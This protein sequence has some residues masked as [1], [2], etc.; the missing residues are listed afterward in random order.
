MPNV[1]DDNVVILRFDNSDFEK[2]T[3]QSMDTLDK[4][5]GSL[6][7]KNGKTFDGIT[8]AANS[9]DLSGLGRS[10][11]T[12]NS[13]FSNMGIVGMSVI[14]RLT[15]SAITSA[16][17]LITAIPKQA[18]QG[19]WQR[20]LNIEQAQFLIEG[21]GFTWKNTAEQAE[22]GMK[23]VYT[24]VDNAV[25]GTRYALDEA[26]IVASQLL[27]S[28]VT[29]MDKLERG[30][31]S[32]SG[33]ASVVN[34]NYG[35][36]GRIFAQVAGQGRMMGDDLLQLQ[37]RGISAADM[38]ADYL[39]INKEAAKSALDSAIAQGRQVKKMEE[40]REHSKLTGADVREMV[41][42]GA[43]DFEI[44]SGSFE[45]LFDQAEKANDTYTGSLANLKSAINRIG[46]SFMTIKMQQLTKI[47]NAL[48]P[49]FKRIKEF[50]DPLAKSV[51]ALS[52]KFSNFLIKG[53][54]DPVGKAIGYE[55]FLKGV[56][57]AAKDTADAVVGSNN[58]NQKSSKKTRS[59]ILKLNKEYQAAR[60]IFYKGTYGTGSNRK[61]AL[62]KIGISYKKTQ[63]II[64]QFYRDGFKWDKIEKQLIK[65]YK[66]KN[67]A[68]DDSTDLS[69]KATDAAE[70]QSKKYPAIIAL[71][72][73]FV[74]VLSSV[75]LLFSG[76]KNVLITIGGAF[77][78][79]ITPGIKSAAN[80]FSSFTEKILN[81][82]KK[83][84]TFSSNF[85]KE[86]PTGEWFSKQSP[87]VQK[88]ITALESGFELIKNVVGSAKDKIVDFFN[89][90]SESELLT[91]I[92]DWI[93]DFADS[94]LDSFINKVDEL[95]SAMSSGT[96][97]GIV[98]VLSKWTSGIS[99][100]NVALEKGENP[101]KRYSKVYDAFRNTISFK[102][103]SSSIGNAELQS[104]SATS[105]TVA[106]LIDVSRSIK[107]A[108]IPETFGGVTE[109]MVNFFSGIGNAAKKIDA[110]EKFNKIFEVFSEVDWESASKTALNIGL[111]AGTLK[112]V[113]DMGNVANAAVG[114]L[115][116][117][118]GF[119]ASLSGLAN[120]YKSQIYV[121]TFSI[122]ALSVAVLV[123]SIVSLA[124]VPKDRLIPAMVG[125]VTIVGMLVGVMALINSSKFDPKKMMEAGAAF[126]LLGA[127]IL[128]ISTSCKILSKIN[129]QDLFKAVTAITIFM[130]MFIMAAKMKG[131]IAKAG[132]TFW[133]MAA[134]VNM[135]AFAVMTFAVMPWGVIL[136][137]ATVI[138]ML[139][140]ELTLASRLARGAD[141]KG[142]AAMALALNL[143]IPPIIIFSIM[144]IDKALRGA[145]VVTSIIAMIGLASRTA[146]ASAGNMMTLF[147][148][149]TMVTSLT[150]ALVVL[151]FIDTEKLLAATL[152]LTATMAALAA[153]A[154]IANTAKAGM[155]VMMATI[156]LM[157]AAII[158]LVKIDAKKAIEVANSL[159]I[160]AASLGVATALFA[161]V[162]PGLALE[163]LAAMAIAVGG[164][165]AIVMALGAIRQIPGANWLMNEGKKFAQL[166]GEAIGSFVGGIVAGAGVA[167]SSGL[168][169][170]GE[171]LSLFMEKIDPF[172]SKASKID[173]KSTEGIKNLSNAIV[174]LTKAEFLDQLS[175]LGG[176][177]SITNFAN[178][179]VTFAS[180]F[181]DFSNKVKEIP[182]GSV[183]KIST[184]TDSIS[185]LATAF[186]KIPKFG[187]IN[188]LTGWT[189]VDAFADGLLDIASVLGDNGET[190]T[191][192]K[193]IT[194]DPELLGENGKINQIAEVITT[195]STAAKKIPKSGGIQQGFTGNT[196]IQ[197]FAEMLGGDG[198]N[199][200]F[201]EM[202]KTFSET[203]PDIK[204]DDKWLQE[205]GKIDKICQVIA[206]LSEAAKQIPPSHGI[207][208]GILGNTTI[209]EFA[210]FL[211]DAMPNLQEFIVTL[212]AEEGNFVI[213]DT[214]ITKINDI[215][216][217]VGA[218]GIAAQKIPPTGGIRG[219]VFGNSDIGKFAEQ[220]GKAIPGI[221]KF[222]NG[223]GADDFTIQDDL[224]GENGKIVKI[225][226][227]IKV[228]ASVAKALPK[229]GGVWQKLTGEKNIGNFG[230]QLKKLLESLEGLDVNV[231]QEALKKAGNGLEAIVP[232]IKNFRDAFPIPTGENLAALGRNAKEFT[233]S[234]NSAKTGNLSDKTSAITSAISSIAK[235]AKKGA[236]SLGDNSGFESAGKNLAG[237]LISGIKSKDKLSSANSAGKTLAKKAI[238][239][240][241]TEE[242]RTAMK[243]GGEYVGQG[244]VEGIKNKF[245]D[246]YKAGKK[247]GQKAKQGQRDGTGESSP[248]K[249][250][251]KGGKYAGEGLVIGMKS[252]ERKVY[253][254]GHSMGRSAVNG[255]T[256][257]LINTIDEISNPVI[258]PVIDLTS[259]RN[260]ISSLDN[261]F[262]RNR[263]L[264]INS[265][266]EAA[267]VRNDNMINSLIK[268]MKNISENQNQPNNYINIKVDG[269]DNPEDFANRFLRQLE[270]EMRT[271]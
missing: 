258:T 203:L 213:T 173:K 108:H 138:G 159:S 229:S 99:E 3:K 208:Q 65:D 215:A 199:K 124:M 151:S 216:S 209:N 141:T 261:V 52:E 101:F 34:A 194:L 225:A 219:L 269:A 1:L 78:R 87:L 43:I 91:T 72:K 18:I 92:K 60:D 220:L 239:G 233:K 30:L 148:M 95:N 37:Q 103:I 160:L 232:A 42:A 111:L 45:K 251:I 142:L 35:D 88:F 28:G 250:F 62:E 184:I 206:A 242:N 189:D 120:A 176:S 127:S 93:K 105:S 25:T 200:G 20:A 165:T 267:S 192:L 143:L 243:R 38:I 26:A 198:E 222:I 7:D 57:T 31:K 211:A 21:L 89:S 29:D 178:D 266:F 170:M 197:E 56:S 119:F 107:N 96:S 44:L 23:D 202:F 85:K 164:I 271:G 190:L 82:A 152:A 137:G 196:T 39:N 9:V 125:V 69:E 104:I 157:S 234:L 245:D 223:V 268:S 33:L 46:E 59:E 49:L 118:S 240:A 19:G 166:L 80:G 98:G 175:I 146:G 130:G 180:G 12:I 162:G 22:K 13:R 128:L 259:V 86:F 106:S 212:G 116:S 191:G 177:N 171:N 252:Y 110:P 246:A 83:F 248:A 36:I 218:L 94:S 63:G 226:Q 236:K 112:I 81:I 48:I 8:K 156:V 47:F 150:A 109:S 253:K 210:A 24:A 144:P 136:K 195:I 61:N 168:P 254:A 217:V 186:D 187:A 228:I 139:M 161:L 11:D 140:V 181:V 238:S 90:F 32:I 2:N 53:I 134:A 214:M 155:G 115:G 40:I 73:S 149:A 14:N 204:I 64:N 241:K 163:G 247:L 237:Q 41:S 265:G 51:G 4:L 263:A 167:I 207:K 158:A 58:K 256:E 179:L 270:M 123:G 188:L 244:F 79:F 15:N 185:D 17:N 262:S 201:A 117:I 55:K 54:I 224:L 121:K 257:A 235:S 133:A 227:V 114:T 260:D 77:K 97:G 231:D 174:Q 100:F 230:K 68:L 172:I 122:I 67:Q 205:G 50:T 102:S 169:I 145:I 129:G 71:F 249:E 76:V 147:T 74:N 154:A 10:I 153:S 126:A 5:K 27:S 193:D 6:N 182:S 132:M 183:D 113:K 221:K 131:E 16:K 75:K 70:T 264:G 66:E 84:N 255:Q 135:L